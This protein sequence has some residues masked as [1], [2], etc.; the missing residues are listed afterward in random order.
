MSKVAAALVFLLA[1]CSVGLA[2]SS[3]VEVLYVETHS[4]PPQQLD[5]LYTYNVNPETAGAEQVG[6][7]LPV[8]TTSIDPLTVNGKHVLYLW[9]GT[10][11]WKYNTNAQGAPEP[12]ASQHLKFGYPYPVFSFLTNPS[13]K[14]AY[15]VT[16][17]ADQQGN[18]YDGI[19]LFT[20]DKTTGDLTDTGKTVATYGPDPYIW[21][22]GYS[23]GN[24][25][26]ALF[27]RWQESAPFTFGIGYDY[28]GVNQTTGMLGPLKLV[29]NSEPSS[30]NDSCGVGITD[31]VVATTANE[32]GSGLGIVQISNNVTGQ[33]ITCQ[34][35]MLS[36]CGDA[37][38]PY[39]DPSGQNVFFL[40]GDTEIA[41]IDFANSQLDA[42][43]SIPELHVPVIF[44]PDSRL[45]YIYSRNMFSINVYAFQASTGEIGAQSSIS[46]ISEPA[47]VTIAAT[48]L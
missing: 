32:G 8:P 33:T 15:A 23:F 36:L 2:S 4:L 28:Y 39:I 45:V 7:P 22:Y 11:V 44:S 19:R 37:G 42:A 38:D 40:D 29:P 6:S 48:T 41:H 46:E 43:S 34:S 10:D 17:W 13:G 20:I 35:S 3:P 9:N 18:N 12:H 47:S 14:F 16:S 24:S 27:A 30:C 21:F 25:G 5:L 31:L 26:K 1:V